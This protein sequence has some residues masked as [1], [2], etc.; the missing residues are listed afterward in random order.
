MPIQLGGESFACAEDMNVLAE[1]NFLYN[2]F[3][4]TRGL[5]EKDLG[6]ALELGESVGVDLPLAEVAIRDLAAGLGVPHEATKE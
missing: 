2:M 5:G 4:H 3:M 1:D 6:L